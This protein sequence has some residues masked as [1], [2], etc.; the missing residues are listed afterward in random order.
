MIADPRMTMLM[1]VMREERLVEE[2]GVGDRT[3]APRVGLV[4]SE[5][6]GNRGTLRDGQRTALMAPA[7]RNDHNPR[8]S[9]STYEMPSEATKTMTE[10]YGTTNDDQVGLVEFGNPQPL[11]L[12]HSLAPIKTRDRHLVRLRIH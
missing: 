4:Y 7:S 12:Q 8:R 1:V 6:Q 2:A 11:P 3:E 10:F 9:T 5:W